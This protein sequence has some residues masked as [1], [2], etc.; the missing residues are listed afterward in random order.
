MAVTREKLTIASSVLEL[1]GATPLVR[2]QRVTDSLKP[3]VEVWEI[4]RTESDGDVTRIA[5]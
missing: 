1:V 3:G 2:L 5:P 4:T